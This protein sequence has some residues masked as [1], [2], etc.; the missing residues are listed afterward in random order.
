MAH[1]MGPKGVAL[2]LHGHIIVVDSQSIFAFQPNCK[3]VG[4]R[5][6]SGPLTVGPHLVAVK[7]DEI[8]VMGF[9]NHSV[10]VF[11]AS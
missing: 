6:D 2:D 9:H 5:G 1:F 10:K 3:L 11:S 8:V 7:K 4:Q